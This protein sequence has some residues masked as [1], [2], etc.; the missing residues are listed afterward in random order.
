[1]C[2]NLSK[3][4]VAILEKIGFNFRDASD[5]KFD[6]RFAE[7]LEFKNTFGHCRVPQKYAENPSLGRWGC[8]LRAAHN[9]LQKGQTPGRA[10]SRVHIAR[11]E[12]IGFKWKL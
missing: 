9:K 3:Y 11:L 4:R 7:L 2:R 10:I 5:T 6:R 8:T 1:M 12:E